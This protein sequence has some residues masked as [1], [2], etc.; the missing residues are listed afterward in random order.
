MSSDAALPADMARL[1]PT[2]VCADRF[3]KLE[4]MLP[5]WLTIP[6]RPAGGYG[7]TIC[8]HRHDGV[9]ARPCPFGPARSIPAS[10][11]TLTSS[12][13]ARWP[14]LPVSPYP[15]DTTN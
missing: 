8:A 12:S 13:W 14:S 10:D 2:P 4:R 7:A 1:I 15:D 3:S 9:E 5:D 11:A 6:I